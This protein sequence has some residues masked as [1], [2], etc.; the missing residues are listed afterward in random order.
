M[1]TSWTSSS[2]RTFA[3]SPP[4]TDYIAGQLLDYTKPR[5]KGNVIDRCAV[6]LDCDDADKDSVD[7]LVEGVKN[8]ECLSVVHST[9]SSTPDKPRVRVVIPLSTVVVPG[10]YTSLCKALMNHLNGGVGRV[11]RAG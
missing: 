2:Q 5:G 3:S 9:Y 8:L 1:K 10:D 4:K 7:K 11:L 6:V